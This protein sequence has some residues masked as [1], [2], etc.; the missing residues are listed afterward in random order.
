MGEPG[1]YITGIDLDVPDRS[2]G[3]GRMVLFHRRD[4]GDGPQIVATWRDGDGDAVWGHGSNPHEAAMAFATALEELAKKVR[5]KAPPAFQMKLAPD[6]CEK[7]EGEG[8]EE[9]D[10]GRK[11]QTTWRK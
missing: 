4:Y 7:C 2:P 11:R 1:E 10:N 9:C 8:C 3:N 5:A 6:L